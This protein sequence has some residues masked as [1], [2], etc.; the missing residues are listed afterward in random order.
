MMEYWCI[1]TPNTPL[2]QYSVSPVTVKNERCGFALT[3]RT[4]LLGID[5]I[6]VVVR[7]LEAA[8]K[9][10]A[11]LGFTVVPG[12]RHPVGTHNGLIALADG[13]YIELI[14]FYRENRQHRWWAPL[15]KGEG[16]VDFCMRTNDLWDDAETMRRAGIRM[17]EPQPWSRT[18][19][20]G[21]QLKWILAIPQEGHR[22][23]APFLIQDETPREERVPRETIHANGADGIVAITVAVQDPVEVRDW[24]R[25]LVR[26]HGEAVEY[27]DLEAHGVSFKV[28]GHALNFLAP[29]SPESPFASLLEA[30]GPSP[31]AVTLKGVA[32]RGALDS[33]LA[34]GAA[35]SLA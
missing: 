17:N 22:G 21:Y 12:G 23:V 16:L 32:Q 9:D 1:R 2:L 25:S 26:R 3:E 33:V 14:A 7:D 27:P 15:Q 19:P 18:R 13:S 34:H 11:R 10:Y 6:V 24:Y 8:M 4:M 30:R 29:S 31:Y 28:R 35:L 5:H 20:D